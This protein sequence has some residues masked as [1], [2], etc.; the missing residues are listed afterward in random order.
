MPPIR[1]GMKKIVRKTLVPSPLLCQGHRQGEGDHIDE[2]QGH[3]GEHAAVN[4]KRVYIKVGSFNAV[5]VISQA[6]PLRVRHRRKF[7]ERKVDAQDT[8][9]ITN[10]IANAAIVGIVKIGQNFLIAF[11]RPPDKFIMPTFLETSHRWKYSALLRYHFQGGGNNSPA[12]LFQVFYEA[13]AASSFSVFQLSTNAGLYRTPSLHRSDPPHIPS[14][15]GPACSSTPRKASW[16]E[17]PG[18]RRSIVRIG[19]LEQDVF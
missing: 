5:D 4:Q 11:I 12:V 9:G 15:P 14:G 17:V 1:F 8:N 7:R 19:Q 13:D 10:P 18:N 16:T 2:D 3:G 6:D